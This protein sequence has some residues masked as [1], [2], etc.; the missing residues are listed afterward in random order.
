MGKIRIGLSGWDYDEWQGGFYPDG[1]PKS[2]RLEHASRQFDT[3]EVNGTFYSLTSPGSCRS[4]K[5]TAPAGFTYSLKGSR[6]ITHMKRLKDASTPLANFLASGILELEEMLGP[7]VWQLPGNLEFDAETLD[8]FLGALP[9]DTDA[10]A[11]M[12]RR[13]DRRVEDVAYGSGDNHRMRHV[14]EVRHESFLQAE[15]ARIA[16]DHGVALCSSHSSEWPYVEEI[17]AGFVYLRLHGPRELYGSPYSESDLD[18]WAQRVLTWRNGGQVE[19]GRRISD[20]SPPPRKERDVYVYFDNTAAGHAPEDA[21]Y[22]R[23]LI[24]SA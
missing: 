19:D 6:Y 9:H 18:L 4:W 24:D 8:A 5:K 17:T 21:A 1:L 12:A 16:R 13:H 20:L 22:L 15:T 23:E 10:A 3:L 14:L 7:I 2:R 11:T